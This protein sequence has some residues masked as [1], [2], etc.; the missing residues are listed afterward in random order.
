MLNAGQQPI[1]LQGGALNDH[2]ETLRIPWVVDLSDFAE[3]LAQSFKNV[4]YGQPH[5]KVAM[6]KGL[7]AYKTPS[8]LDLPYKDILS[9][10]ASDDGGSI[11]GGGDIRR[12][13]G[14][15]WRSDKATVVVLW[16]PGR[17]EDK[18]RLGRTALT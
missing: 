9:T 17:R 1:K 5:I 4:P 3:R 6:H 11:H 10:F 15:V 7:D 8:G 12:W 18:Y 16:E 14:T 13:T 2:E